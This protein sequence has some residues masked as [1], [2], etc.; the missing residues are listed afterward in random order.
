M[1]VNVENLKNDIR[2]FNKFLEEYDEIHLRMYHE[3]FS[4]TS[5][6]NDPHAISYFK[7]I[8]IEKKD[9]STMVMELTSLKDLYEYLIESYEKIGKTIEWNLNYK[10]KIIKSLEA[11]IE[12]LKQILK[13]YDNLKLT[14]LDDIRELIE[15]DKQKIVSNLNMTTNYLEQAQ[16]N[17]NELTRIETE[18]KFKVSKL[19]IGTAIKKIVTN[20]R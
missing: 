10:R 17:Y 5:F 11:Y 9:A 3:F 16:K 19:R 2:R 4:S 12:K 15:T 14:N 1:K 6:W 7:E 18:V 20:N 8:D 13:K